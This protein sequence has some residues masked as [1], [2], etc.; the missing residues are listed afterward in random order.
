MDKRKGIS[1]MNTLK[2]D[3]AG[4]IWDVEIEPKKLPAD[5]ERWRADVENELLSRGYPFTTNQ[6]LA[7]IAYES[8]GNPINKNPTSGAFG[9]TQ[10]L[11]VA[12]KHYNE[13]NKTEFKTHD[14][15]GDPQLQIK[16]G[17]FSLAECYRWALGLLARREHNP[18]TIHAVALYC[19]NW[20]VGN[21]TRA[22][23]KGAT[24][25]EIYNSIPAN[26]RGYVA[27][28]L[29]Y[30]DGFQ[31]TQNIAFFLTSRIPKPTQPIQPI[32]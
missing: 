23:G 12:V 22:V 1:E 18:R 17:V 25:A 20:G 6:I 29:S 14:L 24:M 16:I 19:Y 4:N 27:K 3:E 2:G 11:P 10:L 31:P 15:V 7:L 5:V 26:R 32:Q 13:R 30:M 28:V 8:G 9:L 21:I